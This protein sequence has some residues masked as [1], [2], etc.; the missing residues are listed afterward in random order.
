MLLAI[1]TSFCTSIVGWIFD[2]RLHHRRGL[3]RN[4]LCIRKLGGV[5]FVTG[6]GPRCPPPP[7]IAFALGG[8]FG[9]TEI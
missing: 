4:D 7:P 3:R 9:G 8:A 2:L 1:F 6:V 5:P